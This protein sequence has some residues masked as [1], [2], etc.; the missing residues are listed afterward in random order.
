MNEKN[1]HIIARNRKAEH[2]YF[3]IE[4]LEAG[5]VLE[6][7]E[8]KSLR[9]GH[10]NLKDGYVKIIKNE[11]YL[12]NCHI[13]A[14]K[15]AGVENHEPE[16]VRKLLLHQREIKKL[17]RYVETKG[18]AII[19]LKLYFNTKGV[20]KLEIGIAKG[21]KKYDKRESITAK[22]SKREIDRIRKERF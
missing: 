15:Y 2:D 19:P 4:R 11:A 22:E 5:L 1:D 21:K 10:A 16:R 14:Y 6:G 20:A 9:A 7:T 8:V 17:K 3:I 13:S 12:F 18:N